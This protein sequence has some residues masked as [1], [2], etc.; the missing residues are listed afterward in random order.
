M[1][2]TASAMTTQRRRRFS[3]PLAI[4]CGAPSRAGDTVTGRPPPAEALRG[5]LGAVMASRTRKG[6]RRGLERE[7]GFSRRDLC[8]EAKERARLK[9]VVRSFC[10]LEFSRA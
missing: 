4:H 8:E 5:L 3:R 10:N 7:E 6:V 9:S 2:P 1:Q